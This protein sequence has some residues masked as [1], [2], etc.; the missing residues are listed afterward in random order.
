MTMMRIVIVV[1]ITILLP[2]FN[3]S[4]ETHTKPFSTQRRCNVN[5]S[6]M[7]WALAIIP[8]PTRSSMSPL[9][10][11][12][13]G[14]LSHSKWALHH[15]QEQENLFWHQVARTKNLAESWWGKATF[16][17]P[18][19]TVTLEPL[20]SLIPAQPASAFHLGIQ[21]SLPTWIRNYVRQCNALHFSW[22]FAQLTFSRRYNCSITKSRPYNTKH[23]TRITDCCF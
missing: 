6:S 1:T 3:I 9:L 7:A 2:N 10:L 4:R 14:K 8:R 20:A 18:T 11:L 15:N 12:L 23:Q 19:K 17:K 22:H 21:G 16:P 5:G 13:P